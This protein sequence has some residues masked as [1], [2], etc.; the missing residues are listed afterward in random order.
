MRQVGDGSSRIQALGMIVRSDNC[1]L[2]SQSLRVLQTLSDRDEKLFFVSGALYKTVADEGEK[3]ESCNLLS[4]LNELELHELNRRL[5]LC[6]RTFQ[7]RNPTGFYTLCIP[8]P[9]PQPLFSLSLN[10]HSCI[11]ARPLLFLGS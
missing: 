7:L 11:D 1:L 4:Q 10:L 2:Y 5:G 6:V 9:S 3:E 8:V